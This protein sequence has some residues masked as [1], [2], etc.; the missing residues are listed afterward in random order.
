MAAPSSGMQRECLYAWCDAACPTKQEVATTGMLLLL[1]LLL[2]AVCKHLSGVRHHQHMSMPAR[3]V[4][5]VTPAAS[6]MTAAA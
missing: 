1:L 4:L 2:L 3:R 5:T 6:K